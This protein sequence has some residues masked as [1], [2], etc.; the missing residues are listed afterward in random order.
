MFDSLFTA[1]AIDAL[2]LDEALIEGMLRFE[3]ALAATQADLGVI[4]RTAA[5]VIGEC[6]SRQEFAVK[7]LLRSA[8]Q[9]GNP[10]IPLVKA[11]GKCVAAMDPEAAKYVHMGATSQ[12]VIDTGLVLCTKKALALLTADLKGL[13]EQLIG[14]I[15]RNRRTFLP[16]RTLLQHARPISFGL[17]AAGWLDGITSCR[18]MLQED[19]ATRLAIQFGGAVGSLAASGS[20]GLEILEALARKLELGIPEIPWHTQRTRIGRIG[21]DLA[22]AGTALGKIALDVVLMMQTEVA[23]LAEDLGA[24]GGGSSTLPHKQNPI[25]S[26]KVLAN[27]KRIPA[28]AASL[29]TSMVHEHE[30][31]VGG[32]HAEWLVF[33]E[34][35]RAVGGAAA[36][37]LNL[38][39]GLQVHSERM[40]ANIELSNGLIFAENVSTEL[41]KS[42]GKSAAHSVITRASKT[43]R[44]TGQHLRKVL[45][46]DSA[47]V[48]LVR[49]GALDRLF[50][51]EQDDDMTDELINRVLA[52]SRSKSAV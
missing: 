41:A 40:G 3:S 18:K 42:L 14:L 1:P 15:E 37:A 2:F 6:C 10:A 43:V 19:A 9:D 32:W 20:K 26:T 44:Q 23:E 7:D 30:R 8:E 21:M 46:E 12:D 50:S 4:P 38:I 31:S 45:E 16:G 22:L 28:L 35:I 5:S 36:H 47:L 48:G 33:P 24:G 13:E 17:K 49:A 34:L 39:A 29:L 11:L 27:S 25:A 52:K 51:P